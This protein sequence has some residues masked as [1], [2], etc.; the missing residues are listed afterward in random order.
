MIKIAP[1]ILASTLATIAHAN[2][3]YPPDGCERPAAVVHLERF[4]DNNLSVHSSPIHPSARNEIDELFPGDRVCIIGGNGDWPWLRIQYTRDG[5]NRMGWAH[6]RYLQTDAGRLNTPTRPRRSP[7][8]TRPQGHPR[9]PRRHPG[10]L[11]EATA[12][13]RLEH[14]SL[15]A[16]VD[17]LKPA[18]ATIRDA[19]SMVGTRAFGVS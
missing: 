9:R 4:G 6:G 19:S 8:R 11:V 3:A 13:E 2:P 18:Q 16:H 17:P 12:A 10:A 1:F 14:T 5:R 7:S 15:R